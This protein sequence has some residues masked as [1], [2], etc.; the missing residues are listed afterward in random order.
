M[1]VNADAL[2]P[3]GVIAKLNAQRGLACRKRFGHLGS[4]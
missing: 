3:P 4:E 2:E 1:Y